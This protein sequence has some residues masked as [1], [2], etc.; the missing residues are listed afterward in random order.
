MQ[1]C[2]LSRKEHIVSSINA[3]HR[4]P[5]YLDTYE[6]PSSLHA[7]LDPATALAGVEFVI[8]CVPLQ[9]SQ[10]YLSVRPARRGVSP[11]HRVSPHLSLQLQ[12]L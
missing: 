2:I 7:T 5:D 4:N 3:Q 12:R 11:G 9:A 8:H 6:L 1:V 10:D